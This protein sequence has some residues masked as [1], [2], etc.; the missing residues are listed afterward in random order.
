MSYS[1]LSDKVDI[2]TKHIRKGCSTVNA[3]SL[4]FK[5]YKKTIETCNISLQKFIEEL[6]IDIQDDS[7]TLEIALNGLYSC[8][9]KS[10]ASQIQFCKG[11][12]LDIIEPLELFLE[13]HIETVNVYINSA[14]SSS[15]E[16]NKMKEIMVKNRHIYYKN[17]ATAEKAEKSQC[18]YDEKSIK[19]INQLKNLTNKSSE[20]YI[21]NI[22][23]VNKLIEEF[24]IKVPEQMN[25]LEQNEK[26]RIHFIKLTLEKFIKQVTKSQAI[27]KENLEE[28]IGLVNNVNSDIDIKVFVD[29]HNGKYQ[30]GIKEEFINYQVWKEKRKERNDV[31]E[32][33]TDANYEEVLEKAINYIMCGEENDSDSSWNEI[34]S[35]EPDFN[36]ISEAFKL[37]NYRIYFLDLLES[38]KNKYLLN[39]QKMIMLVAYLKALLTSIVLDN[40]QDPYTFCKILNLLHSFVSNPSQHQRVYLSQLLSSHSIWA[41]KLLWI[42]GI[43]HTI[44]TKILSD[45]ESLKNQP[46]NSKKK[47]GIFSAIKNIANKIPTIFQKDIIGEESDKSA[48]FTVIT[49]FSFYMSHLALPLDVCNSIILLCCQRANLDSDRTCTLLAELEANQR[50]SGEILSPGLRSLRNREKERKRFG[51]CLHIGLVIEYLEPKECL[52]LLNVSKTW[53]NDLQIAVL[54]KCLLSWD[55]SK[56][57]LQR[58]RTITWT[59]LLKGYTREIDYKAFLTRV[60]S[61]PNPAIAEAISLDVAR[62]Y[63]GSTIVSAESLK[64]ILLVYSFYNPEIG[65]CQGMNYIAGTIYSQFQ[66]EEKSFKFMVALIEK[67]KMTELFTRDLPK[68]KQFFYQLDRIIGIELPELHQLFKQISIG[69]GHFSASWFITLFA[70]HLQFRPILLSRLWDLFLLDGWKTIFK[71]AVVILKQLSSELINATFEDIMFALGGIQGNNPVIDV[72]DEDFITRVNEVNITNSLLNDIEAEYFH[73]RKRAEKHTKN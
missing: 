56:A 19:H 67:Y 11:I 46:K 18:L 50:A 2:V 3:L 5:N 1:D 44:S 32:K 71:A 15:K 41:D 52:V 35:E 58:I 54:K 68:L 57:S 70:S 28:T 30:G 7:S 12:Q 47:S 51:K 33:D 60:K 48:A 45:K 42:E 49:Q 13:H 37:S 36:K 25:S 14:D 6:S 21:S 65:Y 55:L 23:S 4:F 59:Y 34:D 53:K 69:S 40:D 66:D 17:S 38:K 39:H 61:S 22:E 20:D 16:L 29:T 62:S 8:L 43:E 31:T 26:S 24:D 64:N 10:I 27:S 73:L 63:Q 72:F 9:K